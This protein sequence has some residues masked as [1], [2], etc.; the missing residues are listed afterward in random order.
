[1]NSAFSTLAADSRADSALSSETALDDVQLHSVLRAARREGRLLCFLDYDGT[2]AEIVPDPAKALMSAAM[3][4]ALHALPSAGVRTAIVTGRSLD[5]IKAFAGAP[6]AQPLQFCFAAS[7]G[8]DIEGAGTH[9]R[10][11]A[12]FR[13]LLLRAAVAMEAALAT[14]PGAAVE[15]NIFSVTAHLRCVDEPLRAGAE[16][17]VRDAVRRLTEGAQGA[18]GEPNL[19]L[20]LRPGKL[21]LEARPLV[22]WDKGRACDAILARP[23]DFFAA[24]SGGATPE[25][26]AL[27]VLA[28]GDDLTDEDT[29]GA[30]LAAERDGRVALAVPVI[31]GAPERASFSRHRLSSVDEV[32]RFLEA[33][34]AD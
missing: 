12:I 10:P 32:R 31:V 28:I 6:D 18:E 34:L 23:D 27:V 33:L 17:A 20:E 1:M 4:R 3:R 7:H 30:L 19:E 21:V 22:E 8:F 24:R 2:L 14:T 5:K 25:A 13:P 29:F 11:F 9:L 26:G 16:R 15:D